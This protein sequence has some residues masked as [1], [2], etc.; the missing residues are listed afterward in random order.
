MAEVSSVVL[1]YATPKVSG[2]M[3][4]CMTV[5]LTC[6]YC[7]EEFDRRPSRVNDD[8]AN[9]CSRSCMGKYRTGEKS[10]RYEGKKID[11]TC[12]QCGGTFREYPSQMKRGRG[13]YCSKECHN[14]WKRENVNGQNHPMWSGGKGVAD[15]VR[16]LL[17][18]RSWRSISRDVRDEEPACRKC[19]THR[20]ELDAPLQV[21][22]VVGVRFG[23][24][25]GR[26]NLMPLCESCHLQTEAYM[27]KILDPVIVDG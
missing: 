22:H 14:A 17:A 8:G 19:G 7:E 1:K 6:E 16:K 11:V 26:W 24:T 25:N 5:T 9:F 10:P 20:D 4:T 18:A 21:H 12:Q 3:D 27:R 13:K 23:G 2:C 15:A